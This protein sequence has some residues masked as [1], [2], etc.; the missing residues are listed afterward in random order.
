[1]VVVV[2]RVLV[3][4]SHLPDLKTT[5]A[6]RQTIANG[7]AAAPT[8]AGTPPP[9]HSSLNRLWKR[10]MK[11]SAAHQTLPQCGT[12]AQEDATATCAKARPASIQIVAMK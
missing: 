1:M 10:S 11:A 4:P 3:M 9:D 7:S 5:A 12:A 6:P 2:R 8:A